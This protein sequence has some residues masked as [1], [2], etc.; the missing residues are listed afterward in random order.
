MSNDVFFRDNRRELF[1]TK[2]KIKNAHR[3]LGRAQ[4]TQERELVNE[5]I[6]NLHAEKN[7]HLKSVIR[8]T[9]A[10]NNQTDTIY[11]KIDLHGLTKEEVEVFFPEYMDTQKQRLQ[12]GYKEVHRFEVVT[13]RGNNSIGEPVLKPYV[14]EYLDDNGI[15]NVLGYGGGSFV[16]TLYKQD[17]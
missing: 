2:D 10:R 17:T 3:S 1:G 12:S 4:S 7:K 15:Q 11:K 8:N 6:I 16:V 9:I 13:G 5:E 14:Q